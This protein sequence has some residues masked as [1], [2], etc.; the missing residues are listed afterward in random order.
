[1]ARSPEGPP[2]GEGIEGF[3]QCVEFGIEHFALDI[4][5]QRFEGNP[6]GEGYLE[7]FPYHGVKHT[8]SVIYRT[9]K[10][11]EAMG[12]SKRDVLLG[13]LAAAFHDTVQNW[14]FHEDGIKRARKTHQNEQDSAGEAREFM[15][16]L[17]E[18][19]GSVVFTQDDIERVENAINLGTVPGFDQ[20][21]GTVIQ[22]GVEQSDDPIVHAIALADIGGGGMLNI[23]KDLDL[24]K[25][26]QALDKQTAFWEATTLF[27]EENLD[28]LTAIHNGEKLSNE[29]KAKYKERMINWL[30]AQVNFI[31]GRE[32][33][34]DSEI[35]RVPGLTN[36]QR[37][38]VRALFSNFQASKDLLSQK[39][40]TLSK[41]S[42]KQVAKAFG[43]KF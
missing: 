19:F 13:M 7:V 32:T 29:T 31:N 1:M 17:N 37:R 14:D 36:R 2:N 43:Y 15:E 9:K 26:T 24:S 18:R 41:R 3:K 23:K 38:K 39:Q 12:A 34:I 33:L 10:I 16:D 27:R 11:L 25:G 42:F 5:K 28:I 40:K 21:L 6:R 30:G 8:S 35:E 4:I 22:P 20:E